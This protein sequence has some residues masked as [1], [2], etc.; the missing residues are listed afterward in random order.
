MKITLVTKIHIILSIGILTVCILAGCTKGMG[1]E[2]RRDRTQDKTELVICMG[3]RPPGE[4]DP[5]KR[6]GLYSQS[7]ILHSTLLKKTADLSVIGDFARDWSVSDDGLVWTF[8][9][10]DG[11]RFSNGDPVTAEDVE[12]TYRMLKADGMNWDL[13]FLEEIEI[14]ADDTIVFR[15]SEP[16]STFF[17]QLTEIV[18]LPRKHYDDDYSENPIG[19]GPYM[20]VQ[21]DKGQQAIFQTNPY[22][23]G[24]KPH[25]DK[26]TLLFLDENAALAAAKNGTVDMIYALPEF[27]DQKIP[28]FKQFSYESNDVRGLSMP[29]QKS[30]YGRSPDGY[31]IGN[32]VTSDPAIRKA[33]FYGL[34]RQAI[35]D[36]VLNGHGKKAYSLVDRMPWWNEETVVEDG[37]VEFARSLLREAGW[38]DVDGDGILEKDGLKAE[39]KLYHPSAD[40]VRTNTA[41]VVAEQ[42]R[43]L[44]I[45]IDLVGSNW[46]EMRTVMHSTP[47]LFAGGRHHP[48]QFYMMHHPSVAGI[49]YSNIVYYDNPAVT[50]YME[51]A[52]HEPSPDAANSLWKLAQWDG[53]TGGSGLGD[54]PYIWLIRLDHVHLGDAR[55][56]VGRQPVHSHGHE[57]SL[58]ANI[59]EWTWNPDAM[60]E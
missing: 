49:S 11:H 40:V 28:G 34:D 21:W 4:F 2:E 35:V 5:R 50:E 58:L 29:T 3:T 20:L 23:H 24:E 55:I 7:Q 6:W 26:F 53:R 8:F 31:P 9:L 51:R 16:R 30:G 47:V 60:S 38:I 52:M 54:A 33:L 44:G 39:F 22:Y 56:D 57:W 43:K 36:T 59:A 25:F 17:A 27:A 46:D 19:S 18:I 10:K 13:S 32:D 42:A 15:L 1:A 45:R 12:F 37:Q 41:I 48:H 14:V